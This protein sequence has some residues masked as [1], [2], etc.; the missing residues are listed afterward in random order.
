M[1]YILV[2]KSP[3]LYIYGN[4]GNMFENNIKIDKEDV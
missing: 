1:A 4:A 2:R 3:G